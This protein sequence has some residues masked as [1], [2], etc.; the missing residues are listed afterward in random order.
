MKTL[1]NFFKAVFNRCEGYIEVRAID[2][3]GK[4]KR[5][6]FPTG[7][8]D[9]LNNKVFSKNSYLKKNN[10]FFGVCTRL[11][12]S[13]KEKDIEQVLTLWL[14]IDCKNEE[15]KQQRLN[16]LDSFHVKPSILVDSG[17]GI[18][19]YWL[20]ANPFR[21][22]S[23][24]DKLYIKG[25]LKGMC[26]ELKADH[27][28]DLS[29]VLR[30]PGTY[31]LKDPNNPLPVKIISINPERKYK[32]K[33]LEK[34]KLEVDDI[35]V[36]DLK[37]EKV[38][39][40]KRFFEILEKDE[41][42]KN[43]WEGNRPDLNDQSKSGYDL[44]LADQLMPYGFDD[45]EIASILINSP[46]GRGK[47]SKQQY[48]QITIR[49]AR[50][51]WNKRQVKKAIISPT[52][53]QLISESLTVKQLLEA[54]LPEEEFLIEKGIMPKKGYVLLA[55]LTKEGKT[56]FALQMALHLVLKITFLGQF[57]IK[58]KVR[59]LYLYAE[60]TQNG[61]RNILNK[62]LEGIRQNTN[63]NEEELDNLVLQGA[64]GLILDNREGNKYLEELVIY[65]RPD[66]IFID[67][68][69][70]F[71]S[72]DLNKLENVTKLIRILNQISEK[73]DCTWVIVHHYRKPSF[74]DISESI[75]KV[76][77][78]SGFANYCDS[79]I[80]LER[81]HKQR[82]SNYKVVNFALR[83]EDTP[84]P[85]YLFRD[86]DTLLYRAV[87]KE[88]AISGRTKVEDVVNILENELKGKASF[89][90]I[91]SLSTHR[92]GVTKTRIQDL[93]QNAKKQ[94]IV[95]KE[96]GKFGEWYIK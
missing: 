15:E 2:R 1:I 14:D 52:V 92:L 30:L 24:E 5:F 48:L 94:G 55:G 33:D 71:T 45:N 79:F 54:D 44:S 32:I 69:S 64:R 90:V 72:R 78:S 4:V 28:F 89:S 59:V 86:A 18:H 41:K 47:E 9:E 70:L 8:I 61:L 68:I 56:I 3:E 11:S 95:D 85:I 12:K 80:G 26:K 7:S 29:R 20:L 31:N 93:L 84:L 88:E 87:S 38:E 73:N 6:F 96:A 34:Y 39:I 25:I 53:Q 57:D 49:K 27:C 21:I 82:S 23:N 63:F 91:V 22:N 60:N 46:S 75:Y 43:T 40:P 50:E 81:A 51:S 16:E 76:M 42:L 65:H 37:L 58:K 74:N 66:V 17:H 35:G 36:F 77:G 10:I 19:V 13:G 62:Q 67:P 83:R